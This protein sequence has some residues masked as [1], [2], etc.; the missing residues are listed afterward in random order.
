LIAN[1]EPMRAL[2]VLMASLVGQHLAHSEA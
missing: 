1:G 2:A